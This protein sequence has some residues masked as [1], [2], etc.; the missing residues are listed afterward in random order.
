[1]NRYVPSL[2]FFNGDDLFALV[3]ATVRADMVGQD[4]FVTL[5]TKGKGRGGQF[6]MGPA[7]VSP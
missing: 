5:R 4:R 2:L 1:L 6:F 7:F 3:N